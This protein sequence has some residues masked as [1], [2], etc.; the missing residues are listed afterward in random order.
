MFYLIAQF[1]WWLI[2]ALMIGAF[3]GFLTCTRDEPRRWG[4]LPALLVA[5]FA[6]L[7]LTLFRVINGV[8]ALWLETG[9]LFLGFYL[10]GCC[11]GCIVRQNFVEAPLPAGGV[12]EWNRNLGDPAPPLG[13]ASESPLIEPGVRAWQ[14]D[15]TGVERPMPAAEPERVFSPAPSVPGIAPGG[16]RGWHVD[17]TDAVAE[18]EVVAAASPL[19][20]VAGEDA[21]E[22]ARPVGLMAPRG[23]KADDLKLIRGIGKQNEGRLHGLGI[24]HF[25]QIAAWTADNA[26]WVGSYLAFPGRIEREGWVAQA[27]DLAAGVDTEFAKRVKRGEVATS[28]DDGTLGQGNVDKPGPRKA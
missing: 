23:G 14:M 26:L 17:Q 12:P 16:V 5:A 19:A 3:V 2:L 9:L 13:M 11:L 15:L 27:R 4:W 18:P 25:D 8:P 1:G 10:A 24:W 22:G 6:A 20:K 28:R 21:I 7:L